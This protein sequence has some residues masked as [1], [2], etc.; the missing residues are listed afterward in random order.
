MEVPE[1]Q[2]GIIEIINISREPGKRAKVAVKSNNP[3]IGAVGTCVGHMG[4]RIQTIIKEIGNEKIDILEWDE[5]P[6][7]FIANSLK[8]AKIN[9]V[10]INN[11]EEKDAT[12][13]VPKD[14]LSLAIG[15]GGVNVRLA[16]KLTNWKLDI[17]SE[18]GEESNEGASLVEKMQAAQETSEESPIDTTEENADGSSL[19]ERLAKDSAA[20]QETETDETPA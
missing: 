6:A 16:V 20:E 3:A 1:I 10:T 4:G 9:Q 18:E 8:P 15:K 13:V 17:V 5:D 19:A 2:D 11:E 12:V 14:Q 7:K